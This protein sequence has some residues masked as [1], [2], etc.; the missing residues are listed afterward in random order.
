MLWVNAMT[1]NEVDRRIAE[2]T[3]ELWNAVAVVA[4]CE[5]DLEEA[6]MRAVRL[7]VRIETLKRL[8]DTLSELALEELIKMCNTP[9]YRYVAKD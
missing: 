4:R 5:K 3:P 1:R 9:C 7:D 8:R 6:R 2:L